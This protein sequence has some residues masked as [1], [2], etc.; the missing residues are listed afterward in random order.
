MRARRSRSPIGDA[1]SRHF[2]PRGRGLHCHPSIEWLGFGSFSPADPCLGAQAPWWTMIV[3]NGDLT[4]PVP[5]APSGHRVRCVAWFPGFHPGLSTFAPLG[6]ERRRIPSSIHP[7]PAFAATRRTATARGAAERNPGSPHPMKPRPNGAH[8]DPARPVP[9]AL[10]GHRVRCVA[11][12]PGFQ[13]WLSPFA[14]LG[15]EHGTP[16][17]PIRPCWSHRFR[18]GFQGPSVRSG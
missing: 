1:P 13:P 3:A 6:H 11:W 8:G 16:E 7:A 5:C 2:R 10:S 15:H 4:R 17:A 9:C 14:P 18:V 12:F